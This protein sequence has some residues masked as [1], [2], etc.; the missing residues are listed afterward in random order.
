MRVTAIVPVLNAIRF[1]PRT[2]PSIL[3]A[4]Q[5]TEGIEII[6]IDNG[7]TDGSLE[8]LLALANEGLRVHQRVGV[9]ISA[10]RNF[11]AELARGEFFSFLDADCAIAKPYFDEA[12]SVLL[13]TQAAATGCEYDVP[14]DPHWIEATWHELHYIG[15]VRQVEYLNAGNFFISR[16]AFQQIGG[17][18]EDLR[19]GEDAELGQRLTRSGYR[20]LAAPKVAAVH[21]GNPKSVREFYRRNVWHGLGMFGT[22]SLQQVD[23]PTTMMMAHL[24]L[25]VCSLVFLVVAP[26]S[27]PLRI[28]VALVLQILI[29]TVTVA[30]RVSRAGSTT[31]FVRG[32]GL[33]WLYY[34]AR[35]EALIRIVVG[36]NSKYA[37]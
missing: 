19:T 20:I 8:Y 30:Y 26:F 35:L 9:S 17:F 37:K 27:W 36:E 23:K 15:R 1:L 33:Y 21:L 5:N 24:L 6:C 11:G 25:T 34:W 7:S 3:D 4:A 14:S 2:I 10:L 12:L 18:R 31:N 29:P 13:S 16:K 28:L 32:V 22:V